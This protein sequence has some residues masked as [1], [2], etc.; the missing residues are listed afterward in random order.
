MLD[1]RTSASV[2][3]C[4]GCRDA[5]SYGELEGKASPLIEAN[6]LEAI[7]SVGD[8][9]GVTLSLAPLASPVETPSPTPVPGEA[10]GLVIGNFH[11]VCS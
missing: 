9:T 6:G 10:V 4:A 8:V 5:G 11:E 2:F 1:A 3:G 7:V